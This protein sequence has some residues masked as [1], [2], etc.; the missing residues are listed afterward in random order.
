VAVASDAVLGCALGADG[1]VRCWGG[2][3]APSG[4]PVVMLPYRCS[5][6]GDGD[7]K[8]RDVGITSFGWWLP[9]GVIV[10]AVM[11]AAC[12]SVRATDGRVFASAD[13]AARA[14]AAHDL[15][16]GPELVEV[17]TLERESVVDGCGWRAT[18]RYVSPGPHFG[19]KSDMVLVSRFPSGPGGQLAPSSASPSPPA[20][21]EAGCAKD[22][23]C[24]GDRICVQ[25]QCAEPAGN[26]P[27]APPAA[28]TPGPQADA[29]VCRADRAVELGG[30]GQ[31]NIYCCEHPSGDHGEALMSSASCMPMSALAPTAR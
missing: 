31:H 23:D 2:S 21:S 13:E 6:R 30:C 7:A 16:C 8:E 17:R 22:T 27:A 5:L 24:K 1:A 3:K 9:A 26:A 18:Y 11:S 29:T 12:T 19:D 14:S 28:P 4:A 15:G 10:G 20:G 25:G